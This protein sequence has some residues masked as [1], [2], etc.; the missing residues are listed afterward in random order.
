MVFILLINLWKFVLLKSC[1]LCLWVAALPWEFI[2]CFVLLTDLLPITTVF[3]DNLT[4][5][6]A[7]HSSGSKFSI[8]SCFIMGLIFEIGFCL[9]G[10]CLEVPWMKIYLD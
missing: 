7:S 2:F 3:P 6:D 5:N 4:G 1:F 8:F 10:D 9:Y